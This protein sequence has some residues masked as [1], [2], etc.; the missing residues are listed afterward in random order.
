MTS[1]RRFIV[2]GVS[3]CAASWINV[4]GTSAARAAQNPDQD[5][6]RAMADGSRE[7]VRTAPTE[8]HRFETPHAT[9]YIDKGLLPA[10]AEREFAQRVD[11]IFAATSTYLQREFNPTRR[12]TAKPAYY[13]TNRAGI[14]H[15]E[16]TRI[17][18]G[19]RRV[20]PSPAIVIHE[21]VHLLLMKN[22]DAPRNRDD[23]TPEEDARMTATAGVWL[24]EGFAGYVCYE[25]APRLNMEPDHLFVKGDR[26]TV[27]EEARQWM[28]DPRGAR[29]LPFVGARGAPEGLLADRA[30]VAAPF[31]VLGQSFIKYLV[32][33]AGRASV[34]RLYEE[35]FDGTRAIADDVKRTTGKPLENW[36]TEWLEA[37]GGSR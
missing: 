11:R 10:D 5:A 31:Y 36:R 35:H 33:H 28:R 15:A 22:P 24:A 17:F 34:T 4:L 23:L 19:A 6:A 30:N 25:L 3:C 21:S 37:I 27:D 2:T 13:L 32:Q 14:S 7:V 26:T 1:Y 8:A 20:I 9:V 29:V 16:S 18:L 12:K